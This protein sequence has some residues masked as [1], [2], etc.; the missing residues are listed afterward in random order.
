[1]ARGTRCRNLQHRSAGVY[2]VDSSGGVNNF[3]RRLRAA[4][5]QELSKL[6]SRKSAASMSVTTIFIRSM[7]WIRGWSG[8]RKSRSRR[9]KRT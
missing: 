6:V 5:R 4:S 7:S 9:A 1:M 3:A 8:S 2:E